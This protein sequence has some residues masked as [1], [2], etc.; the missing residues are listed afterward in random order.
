MARGA[1][2][3]KMKII[4][5]DYIYYKGGYLE[6]HA[7]LFDEKIIAVAPYEELCSSHPEAELLPYVPNSVLYPGF[8]N[9]HVH[10]EFSANRTTLK[11]GSFVEWLYSVIG[12]R[13]EL[14]GE[15]DQ[16]ILDEACA[17]MLRSGVTAFGAIS[18]LGLELEAVARAPQ[19]VVFF[20]ELLGSNPASVDVLYADF[21]SRLEASSLRSDAHI[22]PAIAIH[23]PY[24]VHPIVIKKAMALARERGLIVSAHFLESPQER[25]WLEHGSGEFREFF[26]KL[27]NQERPNNSIGGF[28]DAFDGHSTHFTHCVQAGRSE[29]EAIAGRGHSIAHCP[30]SNRYLGCGRLDLETIHELDIPYTV[31]TDGL[32]SNNT[33]SIFDELR[34]ALMLHEGIDLNTLAR[35]LI[36]A[37][38]VNAADVLRLDC[39]RL[40]A[41]YHAD[42]VLI[43]MDE[44]IDDYDDLPL[45]TI[46]HT[47][48]VTQLYI[49]GERH[50]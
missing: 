36:D 19:R 34:A 12:R 32:S 42:M 6:E 26:K 39:G 40:E 28:L 11:Y 30:R 43:A 25:E 47:R 14:L 20:N 13:D 9:T 17:Q 8:I 22:T 46:L 2:K 31:A 21:L 27:F 18:S 16:K 7:V 15:C 37:V 29:L 5:A 24:S 48:E 35:K 50:V 4:K 38:T 1:K 49:K 10:L 23:S 3:K 44:K 45:W 41:G 33:L